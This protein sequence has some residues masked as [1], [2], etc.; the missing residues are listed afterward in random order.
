MTPT[1]RLRA[2]RRNAR[3]STG[4]RTRAGKARVA[5][6]A[7]SHGL[8]VPIDMLAEYSPTIKSLAALLAGDNAD[9]A[10]LEVAYRVAEAQIDIRR[11][12]LARSALLQRPRPTEVEDGPLAAIIAERLPDLLRLDRYERRALSRRKKAIRALDDIGPTAG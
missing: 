2:N 4:P 9:N 7:L 3:R 6:N 8:A 12:R 5:K 10:R 11:V 1:A